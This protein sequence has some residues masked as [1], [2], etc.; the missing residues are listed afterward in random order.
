MIEVVDLVIVVMVV[1]EPCIAAPP[2]GN[3]DCSVLHSPAGDACDPADG[4]AASAAGVAGRIADVG[5]IHCRV[6]VHTFGLDGSYG[7]CHGEQDTELG[8]CYH[9]VEAARP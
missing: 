9:S 7:D 2:V 1:E 6:M 8:G 5:S 4:A 3:C